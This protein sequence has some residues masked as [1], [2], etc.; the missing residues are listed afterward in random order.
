MTTVSFK[1]YRPPVAAS[2]SWQG[3]HIVSHLLSVSRLLLSIMVRRCV[4]PSGGG[5]SPP[6]M[7]GCTWLNLADG[8]DIFSMVVVGC[9]IIL[10]RVAG[11]TL[12]APGHYISC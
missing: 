5:W 7:S 9:L 4:K 2:T 10:V 1:Q 8:M 12:L 3:H 11:C 6:T